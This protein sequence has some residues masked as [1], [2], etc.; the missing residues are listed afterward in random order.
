M[1]GA[2]VYC[3]IC[4]DWAYCRLLSP[5]LHL[6]MPTLEIRRRLSRA[7]S[8]AASHARLYSVFYSP[9]YSL[10]RIPVSRLQGSSTPHTPHRRAV[11]LIHEETYSL[12]PSRKIMAWDWTRLPK[13]C[14][15]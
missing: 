1:P 7:T 12:I 6:C 5:P 9:L 2:L 11:L 10:T 8:R 3:S 15:T 4:R 13:K 14:F